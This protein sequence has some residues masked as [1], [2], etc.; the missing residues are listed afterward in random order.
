M[1]TQYESGSRKAEIGNRKCEGGRR[2]SESGN[3]KGEVGKRERKGGSLSLLWYLPLF[4]AFF[5]TLPYAKAQ[6]PVIDDFTLVGDTYRTDDLCLRL[7]EERD[8]SSG[9]IWF[10]RPVS[11]SKPFSV[12][13]RLMLG[14]KDSEGADGMV[15]VMTS[16]ANMVGFRGEGIG[17]GGLRPS[18]GIEIDTWL[19]Y[20]LLDPAQDHLAIMA[21]GQVGHYNSNLAGPNAIPNIEDCKRHNFVVLWYPDEKKLAVEIDGAEVISVNKDIINEVFG[22]NDT[23]YWGITAATGRYNN[24]HEVCFDWLAYTPG[25]LPAPAGRLD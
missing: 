20:H 2:K 11:L 17:F 6:I 22:G 5:L 19:N 14:C 16:R 10:K 12:G 3:T 9:A 4:F 23:I 13:L 7:T 25:F 8:Y 18:I 21:N 24:I 1:N 15:F